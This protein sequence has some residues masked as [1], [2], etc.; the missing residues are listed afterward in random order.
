MEAVI[1]YSKSSCQPCRQ[2]KR[3]LDKAG[4]K[5]SEVSLEL[6]PTVAQAFA[7][8]GHLA[9]P[10]VVTPVGTWSGFQ[11]SKLALLG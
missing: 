5:Y 7:A 10:V 2:T 1:V 4:V 3:A 11:P 8:E 9:A 6:H